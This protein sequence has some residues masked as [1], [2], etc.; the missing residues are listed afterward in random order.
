[1]SAH[2]IPQKDKDM[3]EKQ[4]VSPW[5]FNVIREEKQIKHKKYLTST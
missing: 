4:D 1:M 5:I 2:N 3:L